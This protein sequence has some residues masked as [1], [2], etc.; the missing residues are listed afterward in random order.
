MCEWMQ[1]Y[2]LSKVYHLSRV[3]IYIF[4]GP[5]V[6]KVISP[7]VLLMLTPLRHRLTCPDPCPGVAVTPLSHV[8]QA[9]TS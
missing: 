2:N 9:I 5:S 4:K 7:W 3:P 8:M 6:A 1:V